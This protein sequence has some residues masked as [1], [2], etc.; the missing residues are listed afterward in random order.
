MDGNQIYLAV[1]GVTTLGTVII[2]LIRNEH[3][4][5]RL[6]TK[7]EALEKQHNVLTAYGTKPHQE[8]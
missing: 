8:A 7:Q 3:R 2:F 1:H 5:T 6:E 4:L